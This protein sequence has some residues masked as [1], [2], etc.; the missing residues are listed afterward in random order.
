MRV[1]GQGDLDVM[2]SQ[3]RGVLTLDHW[4]AAVMPGFELK[5][6]QIGTDGTNLG[7]FEERLSARN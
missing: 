2:L 3:W 7:L 6:G 5:F 1:R 4:S